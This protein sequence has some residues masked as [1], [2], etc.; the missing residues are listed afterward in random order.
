VDVGFLGPELPQDAVSAEVMEL[1]AALVKVKT[2]NPPGCERAAAELVESYFST[3]SG[4]DV[5]LD[6]FEPERA[7]LIARIEGRGGEGLLFS[8]HLDTV[9]ANAADW[10]FDPYGA[11]VESGWLYGRGACDMKGAVATMAVVVGNLAA[12]GARPSGDLVLAL[13]SGEEVDSCGARRLVDSGV[14]GGVNAIVIGE[15][16]RLDVGVGHKGAL[17]V[18]V[19]TVGVAAHSATPSAGKNAIMLMVEWLTSLDVDDLLSVRSVHGA[20]GEETLS[21][22]MIEGGYAPNVVPD[23]CRMVLDLRTLPGRQH[24]SLGSSLEAHLPPARI[25]IL[26]DSLPV[27]PS[28]DS[29]VCT[30]ACDA[31]REVLDAE[32]IQRNLPFLTDGSAFAAA[33]D[34]PIIIFGPGDERLAHQSDERIAID[35]LISAASCYE[36]IARRVL[37]W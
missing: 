26:R 33:T 3:K 32:P 28:H 16:T 12:S 11:Q 10:T 23:S 7:N 24:G 4:V 14:L 25:S 30:A 34:A 37:T 15:P 20:S 9:P 17:W 31:V 35:H 13:T 2:A 18:E 1:T 27:G 22:N 36:L 19:E 5:E 29:L 6:E 8:G 21:V